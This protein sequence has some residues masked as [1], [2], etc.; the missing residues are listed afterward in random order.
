[1]KTAI[2]FLSAFLLCTGL[3]ILLKI[4][5]VALIKSLYQTHSGRARTVKEICGQ[6]KNRKKDNAV[7]RIIKDSD[8][9]LRNTGR[10]KKINF[11]R[12]LSLIFGFIGFFTGLLTE[13]IFLAFVTAAAGLIVPYLYVTISSNRYYHNLDK[14]MYAGL[15]LISSSYKRHPV[16]VSAVSENIESLPYPLKGAFEQYLFEINYVS[17]DQERAV[18]N[19]KSR[20][21]HAVWRQ[22]CDAVLVCIGDHTRSGMLDCVNELVDITNAQEIAKKD[23]A[24]PIGM[25]VIMIL[26]AAFIG[27]YLSY[28][29]PEIGYAMT[30]T[31]AGKISVAVLAAIILF[32]VVRIVR[33]SRPIKLKEGD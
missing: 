31:A 8:N 26:L 2:K 5:P 18:K 9:M 13:N 19:L 6:L 21:N 25:T 22:W 11:F 10:G 16:F 4:D 20:I 28:T 15:S 14:N 33:V 1:M 29:F 27:P 23:M 7:V 3:F 17:P 30:G 12:T 32:A 24:N